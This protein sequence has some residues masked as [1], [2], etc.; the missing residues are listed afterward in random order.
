LVSKPQKKRP[1]RGLPQLEGPFHDEEYIVKEHKTS[2]IPPKPLHESTPKSSLGNFSMIVAGKIP[3]YTFTYGHILLES[4]S[5][6][7]WR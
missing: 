1:Q 3:A 7:I 4:G 6:T 5:A 2:P